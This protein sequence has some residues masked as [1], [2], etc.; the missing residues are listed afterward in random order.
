MRIELIQARVSTLR[1]RQVLDIVILPILRKR[2]LRNYYI[3]SL[4]KKLQRNGKT[5]FYECGI[6]EQHRV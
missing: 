3:C 2:L 1:A 4:N 5:Y 6:Q